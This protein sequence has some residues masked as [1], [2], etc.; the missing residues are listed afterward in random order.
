M[1]GHVI[2]NVVLHR[3]WTTVGSRLWDMRGSAGCIPPACHGQRVRSMQRLARSRLAVLWKVP[4]ERPHGGFLKSRP[5][6]PRLPR[7]RLAMLLRLLFHV[8]PFWVCFFI[9]PLR[10]HGLGDGR[11]RTACRARS[12]N[13]QCSYPAGDGPA[14]QD[15]GRAGLACSLV[16]HCSI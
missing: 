13:S 7:L 5:S 8:F 10:R 11:L 9:Q 12:L 15:A 16:T 3:T 6:A 4:I 14:G 1:H 2:L